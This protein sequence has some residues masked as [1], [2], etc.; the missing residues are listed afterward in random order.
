MVKFLEMVILITR[1]S[2][3]LNVPKD[4]ADLAKSLG[5]NWATLG[6]SL[7]HGTNCLWELGTLGTLFFL[8]GGS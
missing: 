3:L 2:L 7:E 8:T 6:L 5:N 4:I 1:Q